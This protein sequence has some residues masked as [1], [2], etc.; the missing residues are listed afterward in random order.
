VAGREEV[1]M[2]RVTIVGMWVVALLIGPQVASA[3]EPIKIGLSVWV[4][5]GPL[6]LAQGK[7]FF[8]AQGVDVEFV[9]FEDTKLAYAALA[10]N[11]IVG[12]PPSPQSLLLYVKPDQ[13]FWI[14]AVLDDSRGGDGVLAR[15][16]IK[17]VADLKGHQVAVM[18]GSGSH[19]WLS[20]LLKRA[21]LTEKD[22][23]RV[24]MTSADA[25]AAFV[26]GRVEAA[27]TWEPWLSRAKATP[28]GHVLIDSRQT[29]GVILSTLI[30]REDVLKSR[31]DDIRKVI[32]AIHQA[33]DYWKANPKESIELMARAAGGWLKDPKDFEEALAGVKLYDRV[34][35]Q[36]IMGTKQNPGEIYRLVAEII[37]FWRDRGTLA[38]KDVKPE[39]VIDPS[40]LE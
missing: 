4:G 16:E 9:P 37:D 11:R 36:R 24:N 10:A 35:N 29:P 40:F 6:H 21:G 17:T 14:V 26:A 1:A 34:D 12:Y 28:D 7:G 32:R 39:D 38:W 18:E 30:F 3:L 2:R 33:V 23:V 13:R 20:Y 5:Y 8:K 22:V 25:G 27:V 15:K 31:G 19:F